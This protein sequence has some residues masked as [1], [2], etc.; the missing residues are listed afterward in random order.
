LLT[1]FGLYTTQ[2]YTGFTYHWYLCVRVCTCVVYK[3]KIKIY[4]NNMS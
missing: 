2:Q 3:G 1:V 4:I